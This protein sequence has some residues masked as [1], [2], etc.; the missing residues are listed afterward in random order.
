MLGAFE[1]SSSLKREAVN[2]DT[3][4]N[5]KRLAVSFHSNQGGCALPQF[6]LVLNLYH[7]FE[8]QKERL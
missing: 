3:A 8:S 7:C 6:R 2:T 4:E 5:E 1:C